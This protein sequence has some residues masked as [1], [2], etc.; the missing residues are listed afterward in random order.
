M[1]TLD[2]SFVTANMADQWRDESHE[3][4]IRGNQY[5]YVQ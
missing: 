2:S 1:L 5:S 4:I 3:L